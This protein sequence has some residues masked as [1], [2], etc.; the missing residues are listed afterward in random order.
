M[1][2]G[3]PAEIK[4]GERRVGL[5]P[6]GVRDLIRAGHAVAVQAGAG[7]NAGLSDDSFANEGGEILASPQDVFDFADL[8]IK[9]KEP[10]P[11]EVALLTPDHTLFTYLHLAANPELARSLAASGATCIAY[12][13]IQDPTGALPLLAPMSEIAGRLAALQGVNLLLASAGGP[14]VLL[15]GVPGAPGGRAVVV[16][17]GVAGEQAANMLLGLGVH[18]LV[19]DISLARLRALDARFQGRV[20]TSFSADRTIED[21]LRDTHL[22][23]GAVLVPG[24]HAPRVIRRAH[25]AFLAPGAVLVDIAIDQGGCA[26]TSRP[27]THSQPTYKV[28]GICHA[29]VTNLPAAAAVTATHA[30][31]NATLPFISRLA[32]LT[33]PRSALSDPVLGAGV[34]IVAGEIVH[35]EVRKSIAP[36]TSNGTG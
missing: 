31:T 24:A 35:P 26:E 7:A 1:R 28:D 17:G 27:T 15:P 5:T 36:H 18:V 30:L 32:T 10:Q 3:V 29:A 13:T 8:I 23:I 34:N 20:A 2:I 6:T 21:A 16:G 4:D 14:G 9:V 12:E 11:S 22:V 33:D 25:L 19:L